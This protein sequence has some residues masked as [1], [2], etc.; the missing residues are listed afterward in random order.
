MY[1]R[2]VKQG[3]FKIESVMALFKEFFSELLLS[4][5]NERLANN[6][7]YATVHLRYNFE[8]HAFY[9][10]TNIMEYKNELLVHKEESEHSYSIEEWIINKDTMRTF[11]RQNKIA[12]NVALAIQNVQISQNDT[13]ITALTNAQKNAIYEELIDS[14]FN[15]QI[16][17]DEDKSAALIELNYNPV[18]TE[19]IKQFSVGVTDLTETKF[20]ISCQIP[21]PELQAYMFEILNDNANVILDTSNKTY[22]NLNP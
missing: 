20:L 7:I 3:T 11:S 4:T 2:D 22:N 19:I 17:K 21:Q 16:T 8:T 1:K 18:I 5:N 6:E 14:M 15:E 12:Q 10:V 9:L 13:Q